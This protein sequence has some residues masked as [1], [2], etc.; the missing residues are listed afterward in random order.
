MTQSLE[1][2]TIPART[3]A[4]HSIIW[5]HGL[6]ADGHDFE[7]IVPHL[8]LSAHTRILFPHAPVRAITINGGMP[9]RA[10]Y[11][12]TS[13]ERRHED[14]QGISASFAQLKALYEE[15]RANGIAA[16]N[17]LFAGFSQG[18][19]MA[20]HLGLRLPC[21]GILSLSAYLLDAENTPPADQNHTLP[22]LQIHGEYDNIVPYGLGEAGM[23]ILLHKGY[24]PQWQSYPIAHEVS[25][26]EIAAIADWLHQQGF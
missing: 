17:I 1:R 11:D 16:Q 22:I 4:T 13:F 2:I 15:E 26:E 24:H 20:L 5:L 6:G 8:N 14:S 7:P 21:A 9:M 10:W 3:N 23:E 18:G 12:I 19:A 25:G